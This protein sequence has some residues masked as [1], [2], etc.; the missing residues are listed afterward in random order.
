VLAEGVLAEGVLAEGV[1][2]EGVLAE[3]VLADGVLADGVLAD[4]VLADVVLADVVLAGDAGGCSDSPSRAARPG[5]CQP[6]WRLS[7]GC[8]SPYRMSRATMPTA[9]LTG[10]CCGSFGGWFVTGMCPLPEVCQVETS[11]H[12][13]RP[14]R[15]PNHRRDRLR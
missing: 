7:S 6:N 2:A 8:V 14:N 1:L 5:S 12:T 9:H 3:G 15:H 10:N 13:R 4:G 11:S